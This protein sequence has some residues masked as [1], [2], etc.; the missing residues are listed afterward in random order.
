MELN[1]TARG[2]AIGKFTDAYGQECSLQKS[3]KI[4]DYI[5]LGVDSPKLVVFEDDSKGRYIQ[6]KLPKNW[7]VHSRMHL[8]REQVK[9][10]L[11][12][13]IKFAET[14]ELK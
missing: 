3:S 9:E 10:L 7:D 8:S 14:G 6:T 5:W 13:L 11:P 4:G 1:D 2:F 12:A